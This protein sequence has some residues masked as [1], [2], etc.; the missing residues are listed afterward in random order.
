M[1][2]PYLNWRFGPQVMLRNPYAGN[3]YAT[4]VRLMSPSAAGAGLANWRWH[5][6]NA[7]MPTRYAR[8]LAQW[9]WGSRGKGALGA[10]I[11]LHAPVVRAVIPS[12]RREYRG[13]STPYGG[14]PSWGDY[15]LVVSAAKW[16][17]RGQAAPS[18]VMPGPGPSYGQAVP[19]GGTTFPLLLGLGLVAALTLTGARM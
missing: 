8:R 9:R 10:F 14:I 15:G 2:Y 1:E 6:P 19:L 7:P 18:Y 12:G 16:G 17:R 3:P 5:A 4:G 11:P 13:A